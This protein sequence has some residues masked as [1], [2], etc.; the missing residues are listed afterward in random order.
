MRGPGE[1]GLVGAP[2]HQPH[3]SSR[4]TGSAQP[5]GH[6]ANHR[7]HVYIR[8]RRHR[9]RADLNRRRTDSGRSK[10]V[11]RARNCSGARPRIG[12]MPRLGT[13][14]SGGGTRTVA[15]S[16]APRRHHHDVGGALRKKVQEA[17][18][19]TARRAPTAVSA[20][21]RADPW[22]GGTPTGSNQHRTAILPRRLQATRAN[23]AR[24]SGQRDGGLAERQ[25]AT[26]RAHR[27]HNATQITSPFGPEA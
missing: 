27:R 1:N 17:A 19:T 24:R 25:T 15:H 8:S 4:S 14:P 23:V 18:Q 13:Q 10:L 16:G 22:R 2:D 5:G 7:R 20:Y 21:T 11:G 3:R 6:D 26:A 9:H 12:P